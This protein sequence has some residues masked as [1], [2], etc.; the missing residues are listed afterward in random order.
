VCKAIAPADSGALSPLVE[1]SKL[2]SVP[3]AGAAGG[4][5]PGDILAG[6]KGGKVVGRGPLAR[7]STAGISLSEAAAPRVLCHSHA[8]GPERSFDYGKHHQGAPVPVPP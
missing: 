7:P 1:D 5:E 4:P 2:Q 6:H 8:D 3:G